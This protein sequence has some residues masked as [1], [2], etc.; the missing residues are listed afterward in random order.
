MV[1]TLRFAVITTVVG[2]SAAYGWLAYEHSAAQKV[3]AVASVE[4]SAAE[5]L[6]AT[7]HV[8]LALHR[9]RRTAYDSAALHLVVRRQDSTVTLERAGTSLVRMVVRAAWPIGIDTVATVSADTIRTTKGSV[10]S[11]DLAQS[12]T[13]F[14]AITRSLSSGV[15]VYVE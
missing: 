1:R 2:L 15:V 3:V 10:L 9:V 7:N 8:L 12:P 5:S 14:R 6:A 13:V 11:A 4:Q